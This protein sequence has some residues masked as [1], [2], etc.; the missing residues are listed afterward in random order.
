MSAVT[1]VRADSRKRSSDYFRSV[2]KEHAKIIIRLFSK[3]RSGGS[4]LEDILMDI[5]SSLPFPAGATNIPK[6]VMKNDDFYRA[7]IFSSRYN[8]DRTVFFRP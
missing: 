4:Y 2:T 7:D 6:N 8:V 3:C 5:F 1:H